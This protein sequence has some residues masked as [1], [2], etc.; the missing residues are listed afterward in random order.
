MYF[1]STGSNE[2]HMEANFGGTITISSTG[3]FDIDLRN[4]AYAGF[5]PLHDPLD[6]NGYVTTLPSPESRANHLASGMVVVGVPGPD[7]LLLDGL[8]VD[9]DVKYPANGQYLTIASPYLCDCD[10]NSGGPYCVADPYPRAVDPG[11]FSTLA[12]G[13]RHYVYCSGSDPLGTDAAIVEDESFWIEGETIDSMV[14]GHERWQMPLLDLIGG[15]SPARRAAL[16]THVQELIC[17][18]RWARRL[19]VGPQTPLAGAPGEIG[20]K[21]SSGT[22]IVLAA[23]V[24]MPTFYVTIEAGP[25]LIDFEMGYEAEQW[26]EENWW[27][28]P[29]GW[30]VEWTLE[31]FA[32]IASILATVTTEILA[33]NTS[34]FEI[35]DME[36]L[37]HGIVAHHTRMSPLEIN[38]NLLEIQPELH[39]GARR[40]ASNIPVV[41]QTLI[42]D[43]L[44]E[45]QSCDLENAEDFLD[46]A[47]ALFSCGLTQ[48]ENLVNF[49]T[50]PIV[51]MVK[52]FH[53]LS[54]DV[55][56][57]GAINSVI[58]SAVVEGVTQMEDEAAIA[59][60]IDGWAHD[61]ILLLYYLDVNG[62][63]GDAS[64]DMGVDVGGLT[65]AKA[66]A[67]MTR[68]LP[69]PFSSLCVGTRS[70]SMACLL[71]RAFVGSADSFV[72]QINITQM[73]AKTHYR[74]MDEIAPDMPLTPI[75][76]LDAGLSW[77]YPPVRYCVTGDTPLGAAPYSSQLLANNGLFDYLDMETDDLIEQLRDLNEIEVDSLLEPTPTDWRT[78]CAMFADFR[79][80]ANYFLDEVPLPAG[81]SANFELR[82]LPSRRTNFLINE[83]FVCEDD[84]ACNPIELSP[85]RDRAE[86]ATCSMLADIWYR[87]C[88]DP[89]CPSNPDYDNMLWDVW[90]SAGQTALLVNLL[91][92]LAQIANVPPTVLPTPLATYLAG[93]QNDLAAAGFV[94]PTQRTWP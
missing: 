82:V 69:P 94:V 66:A 52:S 48:L 72:P 49:A 91:T 62:M 40:L 23:Q 55:I 29:L 78:Q 14:A 5:L 6:E 7:C 54:I 89:S 93:C 36:L 51:A 42:G 60:M 16:V 74:S 25:I 26:F 59:G 80:T 70:A 20:K 28:W 45:Y 90:G 31:F 9:G 46:W 88:A 12:S 76:Y 33:P 15:L 56:A 27:S 19:P 58:M 38:P 18:G 47:L 1:R 86:L 67:R 2:A 68:V 34:T 30:L 35:G 8:E 79:I 87:S 37:A 32:T 65:P 81:G 85:L 11:I 75:D 3:G 57:G 43:F 10:P 24:Q 50:A 4:R 13:Q 77:N 17:T 53:A 39:A 83:V 21:V 64:Q 61:Q 44:P 84:A 92:A 71:A 73:G 63:A 41:N 22:G